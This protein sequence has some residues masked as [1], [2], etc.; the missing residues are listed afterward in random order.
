MGHVS[1][2][3]PETTMT[4]ESCFAD[5]Y[6][7]AR[8][9]FLAAAAAAGATIETIRHP[10]RGPDGD[11]LACDIARLGPPRARRALVTISGTHGVEGHC[12]S[13]AQTASL[14]EGLF[15]ALPADTSVVAI[16]AINPHGFA[17]SRRVQLLAR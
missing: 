5:T 16:H 8:A 3:Q 12:G 15:T 17:W 10:L 4:A 7:Q 13:G 2:P 6:S 11:M 14:R 9:R 1:Q